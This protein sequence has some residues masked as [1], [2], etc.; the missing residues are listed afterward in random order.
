MSGSPTWRGWLSG[1]LSGILAN[2]M[3]AP[4]PGT[5]EALLEETRLSALLNKELRKPPG[6]GDAEL[7]HT[8]RVAYRKCQLK[9][10]QA[11]AY[12]LARHASRFG[13]AGPGTCCIA[14][15]WMRQRLAASYK[16]LHDY[17]RQHIQQVEEE[18][19]AAKARRPA[20]I[21]A[22][23]AVH[24]ILP[25]ALQQQPPRLDMCRE[26]ARW[27]EK[28][29]LAEDWCRAEAEYL[30]QQFQ[31]RGMQAAP[32]AATASGAEAAAAAAH[33]PSGETQQGQQ[34]QQQCSGVCGAASNDSAPATPKQPTQPPQQPQ[35]TSSDQ[36]QE[37]RQEEQ[38]QERD[39]AADERHWL[40]S[41]TQRQQ[42]EAPQ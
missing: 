31:L 29:E 9:N 21:A 20:V 40:L 33:M 26:C 28:R 42:Q 23:P 8:L 5:H 37:Q 27:I 32:A 12:K 14:S 13:R 35:H 7:V 36:E 16:A 4:A 3:F 11:K 2:E 6:Q 39:A 19:A 15:G 17:H 41:D 25:E 22:R 1:L 18:L 30:Q 10:L 38:Q 24:L 34:Q